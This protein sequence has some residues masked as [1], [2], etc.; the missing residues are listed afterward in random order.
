MYNLFLQF[1]VTFGSKHRR[2]HDHILLSLLTLPNLEGQ[3]IVFISPRNSVTQ[4]CPWALGSPF[5]ASY[6][7]QGYGGR[8][9]T[10]LH[11]WGERD[12][13]II[14]YIGI[15]FVPHRKFI[16]SPLQIQPGHWGPI[17]I[18][19]R[20]IWDCVPF[21]SP[22]TTRRDYGGGILTRLHTGLT[23][24]QVKD[25]VQV[26]LRPTISRP[27]RLGV[28]S[29]GSRWPDFT[30]LWVTITFFLFHIER[31]LWREGWSVICCAMTQDQVQVMLRPTV[32]RPVWLMT[33]F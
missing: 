18:H 32:S 30:F 15:Q 3:V 22:L 2:T 8:I 14:S 7:S 10:R 21:T 9:L 23:S 6:D 12:L 24:L 5:F 28:V 20:L 33:R 16:S 1:A 27:I 19:Y 31:P 13:S 29:L 17:T 25:Q 4:L 26:M 11:T